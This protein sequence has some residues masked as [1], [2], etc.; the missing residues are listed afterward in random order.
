MRTYRLPRIAFLSVLGALLS[1]CSLSTLSTPIKSNDGRSMTISGQVHGGQQ[2]VAGATIQLYAVGTSS[3]GSASTPLLTQT[4]TTDSS[5]GFNITSLYS[6]NSATLVYLTAV[7]GNPGIGTVNP[8]LAEMVALGPCSAL[9]S[10]TFISVSEVTTVAAVNALAPFM[11]SI[12]SVGSSA[13][14]AAALASAFTL[15]NQFSNFATGTSPG[16]TAPVGTTIPTTLINTLADVMASC[17]NSSGGASYTPS[18]CGEMFSLTTPGNSPAPTNT[19]ASLLYLANNPTLN[20][21]LLYGLIT[22]AAPFQPSLSSAPADFRIRAVPSGTAAFQITP[23]VVTFP[24]GSVG[25][26][27]AA[28]TVT[29]QNTSALPVTLSSITSAGANAADISATHNCGVILAA[30]SAC[31]VQVILTPSASG[32]RT[33]YLRVAS[34]SPFSP[35]FVTLTMNNPVPAISYLSPTFIP[36]GSPNPLYVYVVGSNFLPNSTVQVG[37]VSRLTGFYAS[38]ELVF[39]LTAAEQASPGSYSISVL[40]PAPSGGVSAA[41]TFTVSAAATTP[42]ITRTSPTQFTAGAASTYLY[43]YGQNLV[44]G[45]SIQWNGTTVA[46]SSSFSSTN[47]YYLYTYLPA[48]LLA[49]AGTASVTVTNPAVTPSVSNVLSVPIVNPPPPTLT[50]LS[51]TLVPVNTATTLTLY[52]TNFTSATTVAVNGVTLPSSYSYSSQMTVTLP[53]SAVLT[54]GVETITVSN[55]SGTTAPLYI[56]AYV[57]IYNN[58]MIYNSVNGLFYLSVPSAAGAPYGNSIVSVDPVTGVLG[59]PIPVGS[60]PNRMAITSD[61]KYLWV[62]LDGTDAVRKVDLTA[63]AAGLQFSIGN[64]TVAALAALPGQTDSVVVSTYYTGYTVPTG[65]SLAIY[66]SG[67]ARPS[68]ISFATYAPFPY[69]LIIDGTRNEIYG[70]G[71]VYASSGNYN[72]YTYSASGITLKQATASSLNYGANNTDD[73][74]LAGGT[75]YTSLGQAVNAETGALLGTFYSSANT[76]AQGSIAVDT[77]LGKSF[78]LPESYSTGGTSSSS[79]PV[80]IFNTS[81]YSL[82]ATSF[83]VSIPYFRADYQ[84]QGPTGARLTRWGSNGLAFHGTGG[85][86]SF[87][88]SLVQ[89]ISSL[90]ADLGVTLTSSG[91][92]TTGTTTTYTAKVTNNGPSAASNVAL[93]GFVPSSGVLTSVTPSTGSC[94]TAGT[95]LCSLGGLSNGASATVV[96]KVQQM[97]AGTATMTAQVSATE[98]DPISTNNQATS[99]LTITGNPYYA[100]PTLTAIS[101]SI[102]ASGSADTTVTVTGT[103][104]NSGSMVLLN[105]SALSTSFTSSTTLTAVVPAASLA[106]LGWAGISVSTTPP[107]GGTSSSLPLS[108][109]SVLNLGANHMVYDPYTR[110]I[111]AGIGSGTSSIAGNSILAVTPDTATTGT[112]VALTGSP[113]VLSLTSDGQILYALVPGTSTGSIARFNMLTQQPDFTATGF[114]ATGYNVGLRDIATQ[115]GT[116]NTIAVDEGEYPGI[117]IFD[118]NTSAKTATRRGTATGTYTGTCLAFPLASNLFATDLYSSGSFLENYTVTA[119]GLVNG[120]YPYY[121][122]TGVG[123]TA[124]FKLNGASLYGENGLVANLSG[125][126][127]T[128]AGIVEDVPTNATTYAAPAKDFAADSSLGLVYYFNTSSQ[129]S[130]VRTGITAYN[131]QT[132][133]P[134]TT[135]P[136]PFST[137]ESTTGFSGV[138]MVRWGQDGLAV[139]SA[140]GKLYLV[141]GA[142]IVPQLLK[143]N[144]AA[145]LTTASSISATAGSGNMLLT[146]TGTNFIPGVAVLW[147]GTYRTTTIVDNAHVTVA[148]PASDLAQ[149]GVTTIT[150]VNPGASSSNPLLFTI[151]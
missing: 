6:C 56:T 121:T 74:Q 30:S 37:G 83:P 84:Y 36:A 49:T 32:P 46:T 91:T 45:S 106:Q 116:E 8:N 147:N 140:T 94:S 43:V 29:I 113:T 136:I 73:V 114:Q 123:Y 150:A 52:G 67:V 11:S 138:D 31:S 57:P 5:G 105:G 10:S 97:T 23:A 48:S 107:G 28:Q 18:I 93:A 61:G 41:T 104:F 62:A 75:L 148:I 27:S 26:A 22:P 69:A 63:G 58:S 80:Y 124:C 90:F 112:P 42:V 144:S 115:P 109:Y 55:A 39:Q 65:V 146:L 134:V 143:T 151:Q 2:P 72:T 108:V 149:I 88:T 85:F 34:D 82:A 70:P 95:T 1:G 131:T 7:G 12:S 103:G 89:D 33:A 98:T 133:L 3:D 79:A 132:F 24:L 117:S 19:V 102:V 44:P 47:G 137:L 119:N 16:L 92:N 126:T 66:D 142:S 35:Q 78:I 68:V 64:A 50:S 100:A 118:I 87:H 125:A 9:T 130:S 101:P 81:D 135:I 99:T 59:T 86:V 14:D 21:A 4:V 122:S 40:N 128:L 38:N 139:L 110:K 127:A 76:V 71:T 17:I 15:A 129:Y 54:P 141:R 120:S 13:S 60:E 51:S 96:F 25:V 77:T 53:A 20:T 111:M 145:T